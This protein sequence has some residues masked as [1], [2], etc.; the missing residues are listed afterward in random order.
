VHK[1]SFFSAS[2]SFKPFPSAP[3][4]T[5]PLGPFD[6]GRKIQTEALPI[7]LTSLFVAAWPHER[8]GRH[9]MVR[10]RMQ[11]AEGF[12]ATFLKCLS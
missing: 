6:Y 7:Q 9:Y 2:A 10:V 3:S 1:N 5:P 4:V 8:D 11:Y 12:A